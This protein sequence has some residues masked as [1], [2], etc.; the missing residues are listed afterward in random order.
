MT[1]IP[2]CAMTRSRVS[3]EKASSAP[4]PAAALREAARMSALPRLLVMMM[5][6]FRKLTVRPCSKAQTPSC[7]CEQ[8]CRYWHISVVCKTAEA[9]ACGGVGW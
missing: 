3:S 5:T 7:R 1:G 4:P 9:A 6:A 2:T 8:A